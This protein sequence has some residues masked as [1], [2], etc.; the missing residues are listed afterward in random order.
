MSIF[1]NINLYKDFVA[2]NK[3]FTEKTGYY[4]PKHYKSWITSSEV[5]SKNSLDSQIER[6]KLIFM[7]Y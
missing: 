4:K 7:Y 3:D 1:L 5:L 2:F 6:L